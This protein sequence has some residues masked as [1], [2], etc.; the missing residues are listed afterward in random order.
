MSD[1]RQEFIQ[2][3]RDLADFLE[4]RPTVPTPNGYLNQ[5]VFPSAF[6][7]SARALGAFDKTPSDDFYGAERRFG[8]ITLRLFTDRSAVCKRIVKG[9]RII[10]AEPERTEEV[11][12]WEC[13]ESL[14]AE[15]ESA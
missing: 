7:E 5:Y 8:P 11:V 4:A 3:L 9:T 13:S 1:G 10:P 12:E 15:T 6:R 2:G 14:L